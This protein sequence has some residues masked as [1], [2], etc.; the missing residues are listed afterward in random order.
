M[1]EC[2]R[3]LAAE[4]ASREALAQ[5]FLRRAAW[6]HVSML[7][8]RD[9]APAEAQ[10]FLNRLDRHIDT[11]VREAF[12]AATGRRPDEVDPDEVARHELEDEESEGTDVDMGE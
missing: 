10:P 5:T 9:R 7:E 1:M 11:A 3:E 12:S 4:R 2:E 8:A 6:L